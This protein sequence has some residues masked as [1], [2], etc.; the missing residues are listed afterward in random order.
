MI[1]PP[2]DHGKTVVYIALSLW[3]SITVIGMDNNEEI[4][5]KYVPQMRRNAGESSS[6]PPA[7]E[8]SKE[9]KEPRKPSTTSSMVPRTRQ[10]PGEPTPIPIAPA[11]PIQYQTMSA[12]PWPC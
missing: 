1:D 10:P 9:S 6:K 12:P 8:E 3:V 4:G 2:T 5:E 7:A 11:I